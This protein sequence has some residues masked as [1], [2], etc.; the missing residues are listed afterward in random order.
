[1][2][3]KNNLCRVFFVST[4]LHLIKEKIELDPLSCS[5][6]IIQAKKNP[7]C[8]NILFKI[9]AS[10]LN[11][12]FFLL[13]LLLWF[14]SRKMLPLWVRAEDLRRIDASVEFNHQC[15]LFSP[16]FFYV[17][18]ESLIICS[19]SASS[20]FIAMRPVA[21]VCLTISHLLAGSDTVWLQPEQNVC[22]Q[23]RW[24]RTRCCRWQQ[25]YGVAARK[26][27]NTGLV[28]GRLYRCQQ[29]SF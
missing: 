7:G 2:Q 11:P 20:H 21:F 5:L 9:T 1:M 16:F 12:L 29:W 28:S 25:K 14:P 6:T 15:L 3:I 4:N 13:S 23:I 10:I 22:G 19:R 26:H 24:E 17:H 8:I 27:K 18:V